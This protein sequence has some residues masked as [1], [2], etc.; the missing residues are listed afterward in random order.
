MAGIEAIGAVP[1][2]GS[3]QLMVAGSRY[4][5]PSGENGETHKPKSEGGL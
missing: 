1:S 4:T 2:W 3:L 5:K